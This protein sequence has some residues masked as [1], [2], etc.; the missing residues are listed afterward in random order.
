MWGMHDLFKCNR[1]RINDLNCFNH[2]LFCWFGC[3]LRE[4]FIKILHLF[5]RK[6]CRHH[7]HWQLTR[8]H[9]LMISQ[10]F[11]FNSVENIGE[12]CWRVFIQGQHQRTI[13]LLDDSLCFG[14]QAWQ[15]CRPFSKTR[16]PL[17]KEHHRDG[18]GSNEMSFQYC[19]RIADDL[20]YAALIPLF[21]MKKHS[22]VGSPTWTPSLLRKK[23]R[24]PN[25][26][27]SS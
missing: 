24:L 8:Q 15:W 13:D 4:Y 3:F 12:D 10:N 2:L 16:E 23:K 26:V 18:R 20:T 17:D 9:L 6:G 21:K 25:L 22:P 5:V 11:L 27:F 14:K 1:I 7:I 19:S